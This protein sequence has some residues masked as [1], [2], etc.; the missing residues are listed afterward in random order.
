MPALRYTQGSVWDW[1]FLLAPC[2]SVVGGMCVIIMV[3]RANVTHLPILAIRWLAVAD[4]IFACAYFTYITIKPD[5]QMSWCYAQN[6]LFQFG[7]SSTWLWYVVCDCTA[8]PV[9]TL[10]PLAQPGRTCSP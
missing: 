7:A 3:R 5:G 10:T 1:A 2:L 8:P 9:V 4:I 6:F